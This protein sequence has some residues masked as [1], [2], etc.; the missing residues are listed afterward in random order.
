[1][2]GPCGAS[3]GNGGNSQCLLFPGPPNS[4]NFVS[5]LRTCPAP[6]ILPILHASAPCFLGGGGSGALK[7]PSDR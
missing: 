7:F 5:S 1:M 4:E 2:S 6:G 3:L